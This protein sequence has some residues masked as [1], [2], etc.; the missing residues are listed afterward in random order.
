MKGLILIKQVP[1]LDMV[2]REDWKKI[3][4]ESGALD[5]VNRILNPDDEM[6][7]EMALRWKEQRTKAGEKTTLTVLTVGNVEAERMLKNIAALGVD[8]C[9]RIEAEGM[10]PFLENGRILA[11]QIMAA[12]H[13]MEEF[14][15]I[16]L[17]RQ[18]SPMDRGQMGFLLAG[19]LNWPVFQEVQRLEEEEGKI[20][21]FH[22]LDEGN[23]RTV[24]L[25]PAI[26]LMGTVQGMALRMPTL[27]QKIEAQKKAIERRKW[28]EQAAPTAETERLLEIAAADYA[29]ECHW[30][31]GDST[32]KARE[33][34]ALLRKWR[35][36]E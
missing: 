16:F 23:A 34:A 4:K 19:E 6:A 31:T 36:N 32:E 28:R 10:E 13:D 17:G 1:D 33:L 2:L 22:R 27:K 15:L 7:L 26:L 5:Y 3:G 25:P 21:I 9:I 11:G 29:R 24:F 12:L 8:R 20:R 35:T 14:D 18:A 30:I